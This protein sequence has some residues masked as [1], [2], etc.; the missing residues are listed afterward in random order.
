MERQKL[1]FEVN[2]PTPIKL[3]FDDCVTGQSKYGKYYMYA[4][5]NGDGS[6]EYSLFAPEALH[7]LLKKHKKGA[8]LLVTKIA[9]Q[10][11]QKLVIAWDVQKENAATVN[12]PTDLTNEPNPGDDYFYSTMEKSFE[13]ALRIQNKFNGM[14]NVNQIAITIFIQR[15]RGNHLYAGG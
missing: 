14:A 12:D 4:V 11:G 2:R 10:R 6:T 13:D 1:E 15:S 7:D 5:Q 3:L 9:S 8:N